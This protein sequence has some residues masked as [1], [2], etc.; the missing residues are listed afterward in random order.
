MCRILITVRDTLQAAACILFT[1]YFTTVYIVVQL[2]LQTI[3][4]LN[5]EIFQFFSLKS[6]AYNHE[7]F[8]INSGL[9]WRAYDIYQIYTRN[10]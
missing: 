9:Y 6:V 1:P 10:V 4:V 3:Y 7:R 2:V 5:K 8:Q